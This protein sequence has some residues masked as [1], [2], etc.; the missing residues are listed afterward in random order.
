[1]YRIDVS[2]KA[3]IDIAEAH[4]WFF[5]QSE[6][7]AEQ[8]L[9]KLTATIQ[10]LES[11][12]KRCPIAPEGGDTFPTTLRASCSRAGTAFSSRFA[13]ITCWRSMCGTYRAIMPKGKTST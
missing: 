13:A 5:D 12:P 9:S 3:R 6:D 4:D 8:W 1:M 10:T 7:A 2:L 11:L